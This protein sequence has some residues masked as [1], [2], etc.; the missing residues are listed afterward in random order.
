MKRIGIVIALRSLYP[1]STLALLPGTNVCFLEDSVCS[2]QDDNLIDVI[3]GVMNADE[4]RQNCEGRPSSCKFFSF[5]GP[6]SFPFANSCLLFDSCTSMDECTDCYT[7]ELVC[8]PQYCDAPV[9]GSLG[10]NV[11]QVAIQ[12]Q[13]Y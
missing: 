7:E 1:L 4:C 11:L 5:F 12:A 2:S 8:Y 9:E 13:I 10:E 6:A 3:S